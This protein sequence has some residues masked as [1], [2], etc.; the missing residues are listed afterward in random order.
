MNVPCKWLA[1]SVIAAFLIG[2][3]HA[4]Q[5][6]EAP[7]IEDAVNAPAISETLRKEEMVT[8]PY[9]HDRQRNDYRWPHVIPVEITPSYVY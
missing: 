4:S 9:R 6:C 3:A 5:V 7:R 2:T 8:V 1:S